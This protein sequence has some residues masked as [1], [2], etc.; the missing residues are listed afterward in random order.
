MVSM[1]KAVQNIVLHISFDVWKCMMI[2]TTVTEKANMR[3]VTKLVEKHLT[4]FVFA[5]C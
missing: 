3:H 4:T 2:E 5:V 1:S